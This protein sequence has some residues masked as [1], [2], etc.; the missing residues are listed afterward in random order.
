M[1]R[2]LVL[3]LVLLFS[4]LA[5]AQEPSSAVSGTVE[6]PAAS[7]SGAEACQRA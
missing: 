3:W 6:R 4:A 7:G 2:W 5:L 1:N